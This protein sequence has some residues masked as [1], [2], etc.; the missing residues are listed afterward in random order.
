MDNIFL[1]I[2]LGLVGFFVV[3]VLAKLFVFF[4]KTNYDE[5][6]QKKENKKKEKLKWK[7]CE[8]DLDNVLLNQMMKDRTI[9]FMGNKGSG[10]S[11]MMN[12]FAY[13]LWQKRLDHN[14]RNKRYLHYMKPNYLE[15]EQK[16][17]E[18]KLLPIYSNLDFIDNETQLKKQELEPYFEMRKRAVEGA[19]FCIDE[20]SSYYG[21]EIYNS[22][23]DV[24]KETKRAI[25]E[26]SKKNRHYTNGWILGTE[27]DGDDI[28]K[29]IRE[30][31]YALVHCLQ[32][33][34]YL[35]N[36]GKVIRRLKNFFNCVLPALFTVN[37][38]KVLNEQ[39]FIS[40]KIKTFLKLL[41]PSY[42]SAPV[43]FYTNRQNINNKLKQKYQLFE[44]RFTYGTGEYFIRFTHE[45]I[46]DY[47]T[48]AFKK[49]YDALFDENGNRIKKE[50]DDE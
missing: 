50:T 39:L 15:T 18:E 32:T 25:K 14:K 28:F 26:N 19:I 4:Y 41:L 16:L 48:R 36:T 10:K 11:L 27:Q 31:G 47:N 40:S 49:E 43:E 21:K 44:V 3:Q 34:V 37:V 29:G 23:D 13:F 30:N 2:I 9:V 42:F 1:Y 8:V 6:K 24:D 20:I 35:K 22:E 7:Y 45:D 17:E 46:F 12:L 38:H 33:N 5:R